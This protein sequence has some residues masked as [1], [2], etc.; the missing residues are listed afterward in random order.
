MRARSTRE[1][2]VTPSDVALLATLSQEPN[3]VKA[4]RQLGMTRDRGMYRLRRMEAALGAPAVRTRRG[5][6]GSGTTELTSR[7]KSLLRQG[8]APLGREEGAYAPGRRVLEGTWRGGPDPSVVLRGGL[9]LRVSF[10][11]APGSRVVLA[12]DPESILVAR[13]AFPTSAR[14]VV[15]GRLSS[16]TEEHPHRQLLTVQAGGD[17][18]DAVVTER[19]VRDLGLKVG[20]PVVLYIKATAVHPL[21][22]SPALPI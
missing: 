12:I 22:I 5:G 18:L 16:I 3:L 8:V 2:I 19:A 15:R 13:R 1:R 17:L 10:T 9:A 21:A 7:G 6:R 11:A 20:T 4:C 14:N